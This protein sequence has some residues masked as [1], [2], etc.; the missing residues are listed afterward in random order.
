MMGPAGMDDIIALE[1]RKRPKK[2]KCNEC[3]R[4]IVMRT[5]D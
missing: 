2:E 5:K 1:K 4:R 3:A